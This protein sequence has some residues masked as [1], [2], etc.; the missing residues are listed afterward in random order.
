MELQ[1]YIDGK[2][3]P[4]SEAKVSVFDHGLLYGDGVFEGI[5]AYDGIVFK[6]EEHLKRLW[7]SAHTIMLEIPMTPRE[8]EKA[9]I[10]TL[11]RNKLTSGYIRLVV[12]RGTGPRTIALSLS[13]NRQFH[14]HGQDCTLSGGFVPKGLEIITVRPSESP[15]GRESVDQKPELSQ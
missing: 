12:T 3:Y 4:R 2:W 10:E 11:R 9:V 6:L 7:E 1:I 14:Y 5:R 15:R 13:R 8:M